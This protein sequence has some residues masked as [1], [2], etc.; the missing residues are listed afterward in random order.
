MAEFV[1]QRLDAPYGAEVRDVDPGAGFDERSAASIRQL[2][3]EHGLLLFPDVEFSMAEQQAT[4]ETLVSG[5]PSAPR[6][7]EGS[8]PAG[9]YVSNREPG[10]TSAT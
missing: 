3:Y 5:S 4:V 2:L 9:D 1:V 7:G 8:S 6:V 10:A